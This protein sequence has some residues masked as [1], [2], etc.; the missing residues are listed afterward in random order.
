M[1]EAEKVMYIVVVDDGDK[2][3][4]GNES[5]RSKKI[6]ISI[7]GY[8]SESLKKLVKLKGWQ[9]LVIGELQNVVELEPQRVWVTCL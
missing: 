7:S 2:T 9:V 6:V 1:A 5:F 3:E 4:K 8:P